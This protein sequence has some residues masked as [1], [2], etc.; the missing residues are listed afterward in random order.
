MKTILK[1][2]RK[3][4][5]LIL[6][7]LV[8]TLAYSQCLSS[9]SS[10]IYHGIGVKQDGTMYTWGPGNNGALGNGSNFDNNIPTQVTTMTNVQKVFRG[11]YNTFAIKN[12]GTLWATGANTQGQLGI[13]SSGVG[14]VS[15]TFVPIGTATNWKEISANSLHTIG[16][17][18]NGTLW[19]WGNNEYGSVGDGTAINRN[20]PTQIGTATNWKTVATCIS[21]SFGI[22]TDGSLWCWG[23]NTGLVLGLG[24]SAPLAVYAPTQVGVYGV[25]DTDWDKI[26][27][28]PSSAHVLA[29]K[30]NGALYS[31]GGVWFTI[32][33]FG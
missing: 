11:N 18:T 7:L 32:R 31:W 33:M 23:E 15:F 9:I 21:A 12:N 1:R 5:K 17:R 28:G 2:K 13:G 3:L 16:L 27:G 14:N 20:V 4:V 6:L 30:N 26:A 25:Y 24:D 19:A 29:I 10:G 22:K 8:N